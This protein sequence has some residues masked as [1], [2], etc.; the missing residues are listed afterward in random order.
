MSGKPTRGKPGPLRQTG[1]IEDGSS[2]A[3]ANLKF[4]D[5][6]GGAPHALIRVN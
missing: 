6:S 4:G 3:A 5:Q 2:E 1:K